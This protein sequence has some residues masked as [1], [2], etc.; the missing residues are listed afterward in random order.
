[1]HQRNFLMSSRK[2]SLVRLLSVVLAGCL[3][4]SANA[5]NHNESVDGDLSNSN[6]TPTPLL[7]ALGSNLVTGSNTAGNLDYLRA[8]VPAGHSLTQVILNSYSG[9]DL[10]FAAMQIGNTMVPPS[11][12]SADGLTG[13]THY[14][15]GAGGE[16]IASVGEDMFAAANMP[17]P[18]FGSAGFTPPLGPGSYTFLFQQTNAVATGYQFNFVVVPEPSTVVLGCVGLLGLVGIALRRRRRG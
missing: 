5:A 12:A 4:A 7:L 17:T 3:A 15:T 8:D 10:S 18:R 11:S 16:P 1:M 14:G 13:W 6:T 9:N 2:L